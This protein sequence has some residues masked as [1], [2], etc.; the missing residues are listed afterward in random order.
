MGPILFCRFSPKWL[1][2]GCHTKKEVTMGKSTHFSG[3][4]LYSQVINFMRKD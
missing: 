1:L 3:Q 4:P 2:C